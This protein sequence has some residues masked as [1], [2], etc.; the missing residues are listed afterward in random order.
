MLLTCSYRFITLSLRIVFFAACLAF[1]TTALAQEENDDEPEQDS[2]MLDST[3]MSAVPEDDA[4]SGGSSIFLPMRPFMDSE[5]VTRRP[6]PDSFIRSMRNSDDFWYANHSFDRREPADQY[7]RSA[8][9]PASGGRW[10]RTL[11]W[12]IIIGSFVAVLI[13]YLVSSNVRLFE[14]A[15]PPVPGQ[16]VDDAFSENIY[17]INF[18]DQIQ[19]AIERKDFRFATRMMFLSVLRELADRNIIQYNEK[20][21]NLDY[22]MQLQGTEFFQDFFRITRNFEYT[23][24]GQ[25]DPGEDGFQLIKSSFDNFKKRLY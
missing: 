12:V 17:E 21:T 10:F 4:D 11:I 20:R 8:G 25:F 23:W 13:W 3:E 16:S 5:R 2:I 15:N 9:K 14:R 7:I 24:Y 1:A 19:R 18:R 6:L 22:M